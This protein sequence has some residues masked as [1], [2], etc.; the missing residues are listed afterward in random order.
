MGAPAGDD[1]GGG[2]GEVAAGDADGLDVVGELDG[3]VDSDEGDVVL[4]GLGVPAR[5]DA[6]VDGG[7]RL[8]ALREPG[9]LLVDAHP[10]LEQVQAVRMAAPAIS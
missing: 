3:R 10:E 5:V 1:D 8:L 7:E 9:P 6:D 2:G 4:V